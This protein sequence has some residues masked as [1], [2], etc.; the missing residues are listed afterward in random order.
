MVRCDVKR[1]AQSQ[2]SEENAVCLR[3]SGNSALKITS[4][5]FRLPGFVLNQ[6]LNFGTF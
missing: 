1:L 5:R 6:W 3:D 2:S 4:D